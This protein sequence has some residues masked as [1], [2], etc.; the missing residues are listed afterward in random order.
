M[1]AEIQGY[2]PFSISSLLFSTPLGTL[3]Q[4]LAWPHRKA[5]FIR[6]KLRLREME[7]ESR[8]ADT[9]AE[10]WMQNIPA[11]GLKLPVAMA[12]LQS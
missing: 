4:H 5:S 7:L 9:Q 12:F 6:R 2:G 3:H 1:E 10:H 8:L 11:Q